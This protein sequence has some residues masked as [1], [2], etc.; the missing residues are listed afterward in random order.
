MTGRAVAVLDGAS[1]ALPYDEGLV[2]GLAA[3][4]RD[5]TLFASTTRYNP[6]FL[7]ALRTLPG[8]RVE[9]R[10]VSH[11]V[12]PRWRGVL[13]YAALLAAVWRRR[14][15]FAVVNLQFSILWPLEW[16]LLAA[17]RRRFVFT[18]H[19]AVPHG[20][21]GRRHAPTERFAKLAR[22]LVF[23]SEATRDDFLARYG[24]G[25]AAKSVV[26]AH[27]TLPAAPGLPTLPY[28]AGRP[29]QALV[30]WGNVFPYKGV[31][32][33][34]HLDGPLEVHGRWDPALAPLR[35]RLAARGVALA[36]RFLTPAELQA[37]LARDVVFVLPY[38][39]ASQSGVLYTL[40]HHG[41][42]FLC[43]DVG[44]FGRTLRRF[45][46]EALLLE[47]RTPQA[48]QAALARLRRDDALITQRL[49]HAQSQSD[50]ARTLASADAVYR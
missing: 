29:V 32:L 26:V 21:T 15:D 13:A 8:V 10:A 48:V 40:L 24:A 43:S 4:G 2:R 23:V 12:A 28:R 11:S 5:V 25:Y 27:G 44:D 47:A 14:A 30:F 33:F 3:R 6:E 18:V 36:D 42:R 35:E 1:F 38:H 49:Q 17:L 7:E 46:L 50:W 31:D 39:A 37:L 41:A 19:N 45:G 22:T 20:Y 34:E 16:P 9:A